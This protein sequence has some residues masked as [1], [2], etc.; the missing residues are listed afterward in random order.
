MSE[1]VEHEGT[2]PGAEHRGDVEP[3]ASDGA[4]REPGV[5]SSAT[6]TVESPAPDAAT[7]E[8]PAPHAATPEEPAPRVATPEEPLPDAESPALDV[9]FRELGSLVASVE[10]LDERLQESQ[11]LQM[12]QSDLVDKLHAEN[13]RLRAGELRAATLPLVRDLLRLHDDIGRL[14]RDGEHGHDLDVVQVS[15]LDALA[16]NGITAFEPAARDQFD[17]KQHSAAGVLETDDASLDRTISEVVRV[18]FQWEDG[19][20]IRVAEVRVYKHSSSSGS[21]SAG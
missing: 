14:P 4:E 11:R 19:P 6:T 10:R 7:P 15:L 1:L 16:R 20:T 17:P 9:E 2:D 13:Q 5:P 8:E 21:S 3:T 18:G 12:R